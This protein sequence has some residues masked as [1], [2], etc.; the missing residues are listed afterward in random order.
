MASSLRP[1]TLLARRQTPL[2]SSSLIRVQQRSILPSSY[3]SIRKASNMSLTTLDVS[4]PLPSSS[5]ARQDAQRYP[6]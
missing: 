2:V 6:D 1:L 3:T 4:T 5:K